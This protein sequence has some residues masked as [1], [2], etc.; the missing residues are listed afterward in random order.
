M[1]KQKGKRNW[2]PREMRMVS[3]YLLSHYGDYSYKMRVRLG[4][5]PP[6]APGRFRSQVEERMVGLWRRWADAVVFKPDRVIIIEAAIKP[7]PGD[8]TKLQLYKRLFPHTAELQRF[9][10]LPLALELVYALEDAVVLELAREA[11][12]KVVYFK[13]DWVDDYLSILYPRERRAPL[14]DLKDLTQ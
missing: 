6:P 5:T 3:E 1:A 9:A 12:I 7:D 4:S 11:E 14:G 8:I 2:Q 13:P 10:N